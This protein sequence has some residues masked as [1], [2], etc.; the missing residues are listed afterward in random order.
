M[1]IRPVFSSR[2]PRWLGMVA[3]TLYPYILFAKTRERSFTG[4]DRET[5]KHEMV[6]VRQARQYRHPI[7]FYV[8]YVLQFLWLL[9]MTLQQH[10]ASRSKPPKQNRKGWLRHLYQQAY[11]SNPFEVEAYS[12]EVED[13][14]DA[15]LEELMAAGAIN[16][17]CL[18]LEEL[19]RACQ[20]CGADADDEARN[21]MRSRRKMTFTST[22]GT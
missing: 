10:A 7:L 14:D 19:R 11:N 5:L 15:E 12:R 20:L 16:Y 6:H 18:R 13:L 4:F 9:V 2:I 21:F 17:Q 8:A 1:L 3:L 22:C